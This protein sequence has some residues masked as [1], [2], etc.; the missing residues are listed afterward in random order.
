MAGPHTKFYLDKQNAKWAGV[1][2][3]I[4]DYTGIDVVDLWQHNLYNSEQQLI[5]LV[6]TVAFANAG[7]SLMPS[8]TIA[9]RPPSF[10]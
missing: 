9:T 7:A 3:G 10:S 8:P 2:A 6:K 4:A 1:C 5:C